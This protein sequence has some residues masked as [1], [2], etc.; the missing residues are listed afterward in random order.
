[1]QRHRHAAL[2][3]LLLAAA[4]CAAGGQDLAAL[5]AVCPHFPYVLTFRETASGC[6][7]RIEVPFV[8]RADAFEPET[9]TANVMPPGAKLQ[10]IAAAASSQNGLLPYH[11][12]LMPVLDANGDGK[13]HLTEI[14]TTMTSMHAAAMRALERLSQNPPVGKT[15]YS[16]NPLNQS[17]TDPTGAPIGDAAPPS[18][19]YTQ[20]AEVDSG[21]QSAPPL[22]SSLRHANLSSLIDAATKGLDQNQ[23]AV[24]SAEEFSQGASRILS[25]LFFMYDANDDGELERFEAEEALNGL[26]LTAIQVNAGL[27]LLDFS[28]DGVLSLAEWLRAG[29]LDLAG[30]SLARLLHEIDRT[31]D[32]FLTADEWGRLGTFLL[33]LTWKVK[34]EHVGDPAVHTVEV[35]SSRAS[36]GAAAGHSFVFHAHKCRYCVNKGDSFRS[37]AAAYHPMTERVRSPGLSSALPGPH[38]SLIWSLNADVEDPDRLRV[39]QEIRLGL[40]YSAR[41]EDTWMLLSSRF[42]IGMEV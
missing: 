18:A 34:M 41:L 22:P 37:L 30:D 19:L 40:M 16:F 13:V 32:G 33:V 26:G 31:N 25:S 36:C 23:D 20:L 4:A 1:M 42:A 15:R 38:W 21:S 3:A 8:W 35:T 14:R 2:L 28:R 9:L 10:V 6:E 39:G 12:A 27:A 5:D 7:H 24:V 17:F 29:Q 11:V